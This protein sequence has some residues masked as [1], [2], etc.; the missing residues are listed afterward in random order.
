LRKYTFIFYVL[1]NK[2]KSVTF[3]LASPIQYFRICVGTEGGFFP[4][5][6]VC[7]RAIN[8]WSWRWFVGSL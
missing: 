5:C 1:T 7:F 8:G 4:C 3:S 6:F 2:H